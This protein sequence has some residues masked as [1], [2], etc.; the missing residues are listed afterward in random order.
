MVNIAVG[1]IS[2]SECQ[3][4]DVNGDGQMTVDEI[5]SAVTFAL[6]GCPTTGNRRFS[7]AALAR[8]LRSRLSATVVYNVLPI[9]AAG[10]T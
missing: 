8:F 3:A 2:L 1:N 9:I 7:R 6:D 10:K 4:G 5:L